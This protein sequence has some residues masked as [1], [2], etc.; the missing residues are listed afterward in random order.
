MNIRCLRCKGRLF[1]GRTF[2][3]LQAK[4]AAQKKV[5]TSAKQDYFGES[6]NVFVGHYGYPRL[7]VGFL[8]V[9]EYK[10][11]DDPLLWSRDGYD[12]NRIIGLRSQL[13]NSQFRA[14]VT[15]ARKSE[16]LLEMGK[17]VA[18]AVKPVD[19]EINLEKKPRFSLNFGQ[20]TA[21]YGPRVGLKRA[22]ITENPSIPLK[23]EKVVDDDIRANEA[24]NTLYSK[25]YDEHY[26]TRIL[27]AGTLGLRKNK[28]LVPTR[29]SIT[30]VDDHVCKSLLKEVKEKQ[31]PETGYLAYFGGHLGNYYIILFFPDV[32][33]YELFE[34]YVGG[35]DYEWP[36]ATNYEGCSGRK[37]YAHET[38]GG[39]Y[40]ARLAVAE[41]LK[42]IR[43]HGSCLCLRFITG[44]Y[45]A[46]LGVWVVREAT[47]KALQSRPLEFGSKE[48]MLNYAK[49]LVKKKFGYELDSIIRKSW[50]LKS[51]KE[52]RKLTGFITSR[53]EAPC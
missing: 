5:N 25:G 29:W 6:P 18:M 23:V 21:P 28:K 46:P 8:N 51:M 20:E 2:C 7:N 35:A 52:Q 45:W 36:F 48:L 33:S 10:D 17:E 15:D 40:A 4:I 27:S 49:Q 37:E 13:V 12:I 19:M 41:K 24:V 39:Y 9:E 14:E 43:R 32:W 3:P 34:T 47:R 44:E 50:L 30:A 26:L 31:Y 1:C 22:Q 11:H 16:K 53:K 38:A 42:E